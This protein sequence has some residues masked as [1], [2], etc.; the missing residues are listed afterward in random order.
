MSTVFKLIFLASILAEI[1]SKPSNSAIAD[2]WSPSDLDCAEPELYQGCR[3]L[4]PDDTDCNSYFECSQ[5]R[6]LRNYCPKMNDTMGNQSF[7]LHWDR[8]NNVCVGL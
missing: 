2:R 1:H 6:L 5:G 7:L 8:M 4:F 3:R